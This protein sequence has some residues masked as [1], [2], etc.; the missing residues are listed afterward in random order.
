MINKSA[1][2]IVNK[3]F[4]LLRLKIIF[5]IFNIMYITTPIAFNIKPYSVELSTHEIFMKFRE[6]R[7]F[8]IR[9]AF[10]QINNIEE[11]EVK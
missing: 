10:W 4:I 1:K 11:G 9:I 7:I 6:L 8:G 2:Q 5:N 3:A